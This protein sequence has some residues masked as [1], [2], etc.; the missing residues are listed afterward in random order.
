MHLLPMIYIP[1]NPR[2]LNMFSSIGTYIYSILYVCFACDSIYREYLSLYT[3]YI[4]C[5][6]YLCSSASARNN[7]DWMAIVVFGNRD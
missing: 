5:F 6:I 4:L 1:F 3:A 2:I 7:G